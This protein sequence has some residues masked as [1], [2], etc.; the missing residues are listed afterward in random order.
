MPTVAELREQAREQKIKGWYRLPKAA[1]LSALGR[2]EEARLHQA[3]LTRRKAIA[4]Y[5][6]QLGGGS[7]VKKAQAKGRILRAIQREVGAARAANP[8]IEHGELRQIA[9]RAIAYEVRA[10]KQGK[11]EARRQRGGKR[12]EPVSPRLKGG[13]PLTESHLSALGVPSDATRVGGHKGGLV[14]FVPGKGF[15]P[16]SLESRDPAVLKQVATM[17]RALPSTKSLSENP[18]CPYH[19][20][21]TS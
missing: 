5:A 21:C 1:L 14:Y 11:P 15:T 9:A 16:I 17:L 3:N 7:A 13:L 12:S 2:S 4:S 18:N 8:D 19:N 10:I 6:A 20:A